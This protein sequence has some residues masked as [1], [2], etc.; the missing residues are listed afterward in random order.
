MI[1]QDRVL[2][3]D[4]DGTLC[5][6]RRPDESYA[7]L[8]PDAAMVSRLAHYRDQGYRVVLHTARQ[9]RTYD[10]NVGELN[11]HMLPVLIE[12][13]TRHGIPY[14]EIHVGKPWPGKDGFYVD[15]R[16]VRP[17][18]FLALSAAEISALLDRDAVADAGRK[19]DTRFADEQPPE[20]SA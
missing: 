4:I 7:D 19:T 8:V 13:L 20:E 1:G 11:A 16:T 18:E 12:W 17:A 14:D 15:D 10:G 9:M 6:T 3:L 5:P 2:V